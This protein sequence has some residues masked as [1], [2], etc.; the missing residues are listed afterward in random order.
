MRKSVI[1]NLATFACVVLLGLPPFHSEARAQERSELE[2]GATLR[3]YEIGRPMDALYPLKPDQTPN[4]DRLVRAIDFASESAFWG[5]TGNSEPKPSDYL[6][7]EVSGYLAIEQA[8][9]YAFELTSD[10]GSRLTIDGAVVIDNDGLHAPVARGARSR[11]RRVCTRSGSII[12][13]RP[14]GRCSASRGSRPARPGSPPSPNECC[15]SR[16]G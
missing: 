14:A 5:E 13:S 2:P 4:H 3:I 9:E 7:L 15:G 6:A 11:S 10:D 12:S 8:G 16:R 1:A